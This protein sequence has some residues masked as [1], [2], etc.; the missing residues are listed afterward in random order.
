MRRIFGLIAVLTLMSCSAQKSASDQCPALDFSLYD[1][2]TMMITAGY[3]SGE[4]FSNGG[5]PNSKDCVK[6]RV[7]ELNDAIYDRYNQSY[8]L[9]ANQYGAVVLKRHFPSEFEKVLV[10]RDNVFNTRKMCEI[11]S[12]N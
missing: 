2:A 3:E 9:S 6:K 4:F 1:D 8:Y 11:L 5:Q 7:C 10:E 12:E